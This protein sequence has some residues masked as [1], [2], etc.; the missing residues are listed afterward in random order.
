M[1]YNV[2]CL[3]HRILLF[4]CLQENHPINASEDS[5][6][7]IDQQPESQPHSVEVRGRTRPLGENSESGSKDEPPDVR[8]LNARL[9]VSLYLNQPC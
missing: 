1:S 2:N 7:G 9:D 6:H 5:W 8:L 3:L 4:F